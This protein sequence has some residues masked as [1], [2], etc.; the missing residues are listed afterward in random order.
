MVPTDTL[1]AALQ[2]DARRAGPGLPGRLALAVTLGAIAA[3]AGMML[4][5]GPR[6]DLGLAAGHMLFTL[7]LGLTA[8]LAMAAF[9]LLQAAARP[10][11]PLPRSVLVVPAALLV[12]ALGHEVAT[13]PTAMLGARLVGN[14]SLRC[15]FAIVMLSALPLAGLIAALRC[16]APDDPARAGALAGLTAG[17]LG[18]F[19]YAFHCADDS[20]L[21]VATWYVIAIALLVG[22]GAAAGRRL[23]SW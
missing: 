6:P 19:F 4:S 2:R 14:S 20:P 17:A 16:A 11:A 9:A 8:T 13:Q 1:I 10:A 7:K 12:F 21:F 22:I 5:M 18:A 23:L 15:V 3:C